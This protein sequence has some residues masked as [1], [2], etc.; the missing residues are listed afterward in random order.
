[1]SQTSGFKTQGGQHIVSFMLKTYYKIH[2]VGSVFTNEKQDA[3]WLA[4]IL[5]KKIEDLE[6][7]YNFY[8]TTISSDNAYTCSK[9][10]GLLNGL[11]DDVTQ[12]QEAETKLDHHIVLLRCTAH[13][14]DLCLKDY[15]EYFDVKEKLD[16]LAK[17]SKVGISVVPTRWTSFKTAFDKIIDKIGQLPEDMQ[18]HNDIVAMIS[19]TILQVEANYISHSRWGSLIS[20]LLNNLQK[21]VD[22]NIGINNDIVE[23]ANIMIMIVKERQDQYMATHNKITKFL[24]L[25]DPL[26]EETREQ[27]PALKYNVFKQSCKQIGKKFSIKYFENNYNQISDKMNQ[28]PTLVENARQ[29]LYNSV[30]GKDDQIA[31]LKY[32][33]KENGEIQAALSQFSTMTVSNGSVERLFSFYHRQTMA[34]EGSSAQ[35]PSQIKIQ[36]RFIIVYSSPILRLTQLSLCVEQQ[37]FQ[38]QVNLLEQT[39]LVTKTEALEAY[40]DELNYYQTTQR[41]LKSKMFLKYPSLTNFNVKN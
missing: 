17:Y 36:L 5:K 37:F 16:A 22:D 19:I 18:S 31:Y 25:L 24:N 34:N 20:Q 14:L 26:N 15:C 9:V 41:Q 1:M 32:V 40:A 39:T 28:C 13:V 4:K 29:Y 11:R 10:H 12:Q 6:N 2:F 38:N 3:I 27:D 8:I 35:L 33:W 21:L 23:R 30:N 7:R